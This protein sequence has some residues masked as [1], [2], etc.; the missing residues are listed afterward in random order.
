MTKYVVKFE[1]IDNNEEIIQREEYDLVISEFDH[2]K[3]FLKKYAG[4]PTI[5]REIIEKL[6]QTS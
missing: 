5:R 2:L 6:D 3:N 4:R 1:K